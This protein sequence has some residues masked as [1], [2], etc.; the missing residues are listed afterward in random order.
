LGETL[1]QG[2]ESLNGKLLEDIDRH[3]T[4]GHSYFLHRK[5]NRSVLEGIWNQEVFPLIEDYFF[6]R[7]DKAGE[8]TFES[9]WPNA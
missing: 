3:H 4:I 5:M 1:L 7:P 9:F 8:Y 6:D 2:I